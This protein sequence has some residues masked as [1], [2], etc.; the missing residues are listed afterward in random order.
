APPQSQHH[1]QRNEYGIGGKPGDEARTLPASDLELAS[2]R[3]EPAGDLK[4]IGK[5]HVGTFAHPGEMET[6]SMPLHPHQPS[7]HSGLKAN[8]KCGASIARQPSEPQAPARL[9]AHA[10]L[11][12]RGMPLM[13]VFS[14]SDRAIETPNRRVPR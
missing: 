8:R 12:P 9:Q 7:R 14:S 5:R 10:V 11:L 6:L 13:S 1:A 4:T 3:Q 2:H